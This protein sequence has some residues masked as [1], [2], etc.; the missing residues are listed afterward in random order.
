MNKPA[1]L[2]ALPLVLASSH[3]VAGSLSGKEIMTRN[4]EARKVSEFE[5]KSR[6]VSG[7]QDSAGD[8]I[9]EFSFWRK[10]QQDGVHNSTFT[11]FH[12]PAEVKNEGI[13]IVENPSGKNDVLLY[14]PAYKKIRRVE[15]QQQSGSFMGSVFS[16]SDIATPHVDEYD[17]KVMKEEKCPSAEG[18]SVQC[19]QV[20]AVPANE[21]V[22]TRTGYTRSVAWVR[23]DNFMVVKAEY[24]NLEGEL[25]KRLEASKIK[26][27]DDKNKKWLAHEL[28][29]VNL[30]TKE[31]TRLTF[32]NVK[33]NQGIPDSVFTQQ[34]LQ[35][36]R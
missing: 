15:S 14:L 18:A 9:K 24:T 23:Q 16:Y 34:N 36:V 33:V 29:I 32:E 22:K 30:K 25:F 35:K 4:E 28:F 3:A 1:L 19:Y 20:E 26:M 6:L 11:R 13:L 31:F 5:S 7:T 10:V 17:Y 2:L 12:S 27:V 8:K 21:E